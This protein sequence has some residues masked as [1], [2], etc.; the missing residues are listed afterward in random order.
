LQGFFALFDPPAGAYLLGHVVGEHQQPVG[1]APGV[2]P[3]LVGKVPVPVFGRGA[4]VRTMGT[5]TSWP[6]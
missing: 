1:F 3:R 2:A 4:G 6:W 5:R